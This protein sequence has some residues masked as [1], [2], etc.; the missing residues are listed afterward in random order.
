M[1]PFSP[2]NWNEDDD[3]VM[4]VLDGMLHIESA[5]LHDDTLPYLGRERRRRW[6]A[7]AWGGIAQVSPSLV[8]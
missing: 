3:F 5:L 6:S 2:F 1:L 7:G 4:L 8:L